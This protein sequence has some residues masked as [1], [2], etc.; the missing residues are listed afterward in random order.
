ME[1]SPISLLTKASRE[2][3]S[4][5]KPVPR[6]RRSR[7]RQLVW[8]LMKGSD[9]FLT[10][11]QVHAL[12]AEA[13]ATVGLATVY[14]NLQ[15]LEADGQLDTIYNSDGEMAYRYCSAGHHHHLI[16]R[17]CATAVEISGGDLETWSDAIAREH[18]FTDPDHF[19]E[20]YGICPACQDP[21]SQ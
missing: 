8:D 9:E 5:S 11:Q 2:S 4:M 18:G 17:S 6:V 19:A 7:Q 21:T 15:A 13:G 20:I 14:R 10:A 16:C 3:H 1:N 12:L